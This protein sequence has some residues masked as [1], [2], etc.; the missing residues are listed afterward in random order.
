MTIKWSMVPEK[1]SPMNVI[2]GHFSPFFPIYPHEKSK[3]LKKLKKQ[4][5]ILS[6]YTCVPHMKIMLYLVLEIWRAMD[7]IFY[8]FCPSPAPSSSNNP[9]NQNWK[10]WKKHLRYHLFTHAYQKLWSHD[11]WFRRYGDQLTERQRNKQTDIQ[12]GG[13]MDRQIEKV[14]YTDRYPI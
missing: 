7:I 10:K 13:G 12:K 1:W 5:E 6:F 11:E 3:F 4:L 9:K 2:F 8:N 14:T